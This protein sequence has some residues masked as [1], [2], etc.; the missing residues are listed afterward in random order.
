MEP[1]EIIDQEIDA[2]MQKAWNA[3]QYIQKLFIKREKGFF[4]CYCG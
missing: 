4:V 1:K 2:V 3:F